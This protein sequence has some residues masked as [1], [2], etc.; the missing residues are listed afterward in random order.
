ML[1]VLYADNLVVNFDLTNARAQSVAARLATDLSA[2]AQQATFQ[3][4]IHLT[5]LSGLL[6]WRLL[7]GGGE[8]GTVINEFDASKSDQLAALHVS[9]GGVAR[10]PSSATW[11]GILG[12]HCGYAKYVWEPGGATSCMLNLGATWAI[13]R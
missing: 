2:T 9:L 13:I 10:L 1:R 11:A 6:Q 8:V 5:T 4:G 3:G 7:L 12:V